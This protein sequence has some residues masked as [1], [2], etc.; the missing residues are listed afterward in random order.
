M[1]SEPG[2]V[3]SLSTGVIDLWFHWLVCDPASRQ[4]QPS[5]WDAGQKFKSPWLCFVTGLQLPHR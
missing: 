5:H 3:F 1:V 2:W 4:R